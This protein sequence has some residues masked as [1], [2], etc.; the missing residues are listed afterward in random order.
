MQVCGRVLPKGTE[1][2]MPV[3]SL[4]YNKGVWGEDAAQWRPDRWLEG[5]SVAAARKDADGNLRFMP[6]LDG[7]SNCIGQHLALVRFWRT[8]MSVGYT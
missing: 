4:H 6:F 8:R 7:P 5:G 2:M 1:V 3:W